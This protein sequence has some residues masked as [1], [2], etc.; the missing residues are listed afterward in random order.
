[1]NITQLEKQVLSAIL[2]MMAEYEEVREADD[3]V[4]CWTWT[5]RL[6]KQGVGALSSLVRKG[7]IETD[8]N[9]DESGKAR[10]SHDSRCSLTDQGVAACV[11][12]ELLIPEGEYKNVFTC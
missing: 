9:T 11:E 1:M 2:E 12:H 10:P 7:L 3:L 6:T 5:P 4:G 8:Y